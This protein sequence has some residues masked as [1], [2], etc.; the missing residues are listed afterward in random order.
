MAYLKPGRSLLMANWLMQ[1][2]RIKQTLTVVGR[3]S[4]QPRSVTVNVHTHAG[5]QYLVAPR[6]ETQWVHN[7]RKAGEAELS[8][9]KGRRTIMA[10]EIVDDTKLEIIDSY[11]ERWKKEVA[12]YWKRLPDPDDHP[13]FE[14]ADK[15]SE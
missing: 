3:S 12:G 13:V 8:D 10:T 11:V 1:K 15:S 2:L 9:R 7:I 6:G 4:G 5:K 14:I